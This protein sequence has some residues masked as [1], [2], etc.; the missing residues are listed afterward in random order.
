MSD[1]ATA[2]G[3]LAAFWASSN[4]RRTAWAL[5]LLLPLLW[6]LGGTSLFDVDEGAFS[7]ATREM[8]AND[9]WGHTTLNAAPRFDKPIGIYW[10]QA[11]SVHLFGLNEFALRLPSALSCWLMAL[12]LGIFA[13]QRWGERAGALAG[14]ITVSSLGY[15]V[16]GR[17]ATADSLLNLLLVLSALDVWRFAENGSRTALRRAYAWVGLG[18]LVKGPVAILVPGAAFFL[19]CATSRRWSLLWSALRDAWGWVLLL[20]IAVPWYAYA[21]H[22]DGMAFVDGFLMHHNVDRFTGTVGGHR[23]ALGYYVL[24]LPVLALPWAPLMAFVLARARRLWAEPVSRYLLAWA[25]F[26][27]VFFSLSGT[28]LPHYVLYGYAPWVLLM[29]RVL[30]QATR[31]VAVVAGAGI[32]VWALGVVAAPQIVAAYA[33]HVRDALYHALL[34]GA[35]AANW[36]P[37]ALAL[38]AIAVLFAWRGAAEWRLPAAALVVTL[39]IGGWSLPWFGETL[40]G[41]VRRAAAVA[42]ARPERTVQWGIH[43]PSFA[44]YAGRVVPKGDPTPQDMVLA[45]ADQPP[46][47]PPRTPLFEER[48]IVL[49]APLA[50]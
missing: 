36:W 25:A 18:L 44:V 47:G 42:A 38:A 9:D 22:R 7:E 46:P 1:R 23:G 48:G 33:P 41:P 32:V 26:I 20:V 30:S 50:H 3:G 8:L 28:K 12:A 10:L 15:L 37:P 6:H 19:W 49:L 29:A 43:L 11:T 40:Q 13:A 14:V 31:R 34:S 4:V 39:L 27:L 24:M 2:R 21:L 17:A 45:R 35:P 5:V 16:I